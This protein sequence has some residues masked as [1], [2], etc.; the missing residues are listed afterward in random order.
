MKNAILV[1]AVLSISIFAC[2]KNHNT[3]TAPPPTTTPTGKID[4][5]YGCISRL[6]TT[7]KDIIVKPDDYIYA[8]QLLQSGNID[9]SNFKILSVRYDTFKNY[10][11]QIKHEVIIFEQQFINNLPLL[12]IEGEYVF[13]D[14]LFDWTGGKF[15]TSCSLDTIPALRLTQVRKLYVTALAASNSPAYLKTY[16]DSCLVAEFGYYDINSGTVNH[17]INFVKAWHVYPINSGL[18]TAYFNDNGTL[19]WFAN[20]I[21]N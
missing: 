5:D 17:T 12:N 8:Q 9:Q 3:V 13:M 11:N 18:P 10:N 6:V 15:A 16:K 4:D 21:V 14:G 19:L 2:K 7:P 1:F 20:G